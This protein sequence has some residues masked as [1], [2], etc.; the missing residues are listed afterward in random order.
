MIADAF[1]AHAGAGWQ[2]CEDV[3]TYDNARLCEALLR[4]GTALGS[5]R[6]VDIGPRDARVLR[7]GRDRS[8]C[9]TGRSHVR[10]G[11]QRRLVSA[12]RHE[13]AQR[14]AAARSGG[15]GRRGVRG[16]RRH[17]RRAL[18]Q[19]RGDRARVVF[20]AQ[21]RTRIAVATESGCRDGIDDAGVNANMGAESTVCYL[22]SAIALANRSTKT[23]RLAR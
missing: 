21:H 18:A 7:R 10:A 23:L 20:R 15:D 1:D 4:G 2:W 5:E 22:M 14:A 16:A 12:R 6:Y 11:R 9:V 13:G 17:R 19:R 3:M 8:G